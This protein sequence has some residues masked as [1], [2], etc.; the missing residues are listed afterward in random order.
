MARIFI[1]YRR[2]DSAYV[3][4]SLRDA[5]HARFGTDS[6]FFDVDNIPFG[7][8]FRKYIGN[9]VGQCD[10]LLV[11][12]GDQWLHSTNDQGRR[13]IEDPSDYVRIEIESA[14]KRDIPVIPVLVGEAKVPGASELP[15]SIRDMVFRNAAEIRATRD[16][17]NHIQR[18]VDGLEEHLQ[19]KVSEAVENKPVAPRKQE[20]SVSQPREATAQPKKRESAKAKPPVG[21]PDTEKERLATSRKRSSVPEPGK[22]EAAELGTERVALMS[23]LQAR[24]SMQSIAAESMPPISPPALDQRA[25]FLKKIRKAFKGVTHNSLY[26]C[27]AIPPEKASAAT[28][29][30]APNVAPDAI[31]LLYDNTILGGAKDGFLL[32]VDAIYWRNN[33][34]NTGHYRFADIHRIAST[35]SVAFAI[36]RTKILRMDRAVAGGADELTSQ[37]KTR[38]AGRRTRGS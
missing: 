7:A 5:L 11:L 9:A 10:V 33:L 6:V 38:G 34:H 23:L 31:M 25:A 12:I 19:A 3:A 27:G 20:P 13:Q 8:D 29:A 21:V 36:N 17:K 35:P 18:L 24:A 32:T 15:E 16:Q 1:S 4:S 37:F 30:Y 22:M 14:L 2:R 26:F 28:K